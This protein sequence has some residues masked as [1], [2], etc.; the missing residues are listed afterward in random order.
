MTSATQSPTETAR[1]AQLLR[2]SWN[3]VKGP[4][5]TAL[6]AVAA[7]FLFHPPLAQGIYYLLRGLWPLFRLGSLH[8]SSAT[9]TDVWLAQSGGVLT[10]VIG[11][12]L[13]LAAYRRQGS[14]EILLLAF[15]SAL[16]LTLLELIFVCQ[17]RISKVY[18]LDAIIQVGLVAFWVYGWRKTERALAQSAAVSRAALPPSEIAAQPAAAVPAAFS[19]PL[20]R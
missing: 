13:C 17:E 9:D 5:A 18:L 1:R 19:P 11:A 20:A 10:L 7:F 2:D 3:R 15:G 12:T 4:S 14:P 16:G 6:G 8:N